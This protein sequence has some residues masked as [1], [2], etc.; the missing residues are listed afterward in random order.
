VAAAGA[1]PTAA[2]AARTPAK[3]K[4]QAAVTPPARVKRGIA[5]SSPVAR[6]LSKGPSPTA[7]DGTAA[8]FAGLKF[9]ATGYKMG[10]A[11]HPLHKPSVELHELIALHGG[12]VVDDIGSSSGV[13]LDHAVVVLIADQP[14]RTLKYLYGLARRTPPLTLEWV[15]A[16]AKAGSLVPPEQFTLPAGKSAVTHELVPFI[17]PFS[18]LLSA[19][20]VSSAGLVKTHESKRASH[21]SARKQRAPVSAS[22]SRSSAAAGSSAADASLSSAESQSL[23]DLGIDVAARLAGVTRSERVFSGCVLCVHGSPQWTAEFSWLLYEAGAEVVPPAADDAVLPEGVQYLVSEHPDDASGGLS[24]PA[25]S[26]P[27]GKRGGKRGAAARRGR[28]T[29]SKRGRLSSKAA[30]AKAAAAS[31]ADDDSDD[32]PVPSLIVQAEQLGVPVVSKD[33]VIECLLRQRVQPPI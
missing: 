32:E 25:R 8:V 11:T 31:G 2:S 17:S 33:W 20:D 9:L 27:A 24:E 15:R 30:G 6:K 21:A 13:S 1:S 19:A 12:T 26:S 18:H 7:T 4:D 3:L 10:D 5:A 22:R 16:C 23:N 28:G 29:A 14:L